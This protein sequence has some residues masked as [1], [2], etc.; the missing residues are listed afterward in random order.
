[1]TEG[2]EIKNLR[3]KLKKEIDFFDKWRGETFFK[4]WTEFQGKL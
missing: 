3:I 2:K 4:I 1:M